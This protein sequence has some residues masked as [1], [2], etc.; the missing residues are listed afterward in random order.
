MKY[1]VVY[2]KD[3]KPGDIIIR[4][5]SRI[6]FLDF[7]QCQG[8]GCWMG[9]YGLIDGKVYLEIAKKWDSPETFRVFQNEPIVREIN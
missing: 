6:K 2:P 3:L 8:M 7:T 4:G 9:T 1:E 5:I